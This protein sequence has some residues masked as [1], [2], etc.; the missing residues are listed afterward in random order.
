MPPLS[1]RSFSL[2]FLG[3]ESHLLPMLEFRII[4]EARNPAR[5]CSRRYRDDFVIRI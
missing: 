4:L 2:A 3:K 5:R 1:I